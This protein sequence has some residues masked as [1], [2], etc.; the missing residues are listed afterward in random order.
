MIDLEGKK[1]LLYI[2]KIL[3][4][5]T[6]RQSC[7]AIRIQ[8]WWKGYAIRKKYGEQI[9]SFRNKKVDSEPENIEQEQNVKVKIQEDMKVE[10]ITETPVVAP[11]P[12]KKAVTSQKKATAKAATASKPLRSAASER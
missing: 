2:A 12:V 9:A 7:S 3:R 1:L 5:E 10:D 6:F 11:P 8:R 4:I